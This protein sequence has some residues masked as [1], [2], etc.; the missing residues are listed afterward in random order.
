MP[1][2]SRHQ[3]TTL[4]DGDFHRNPKGY[5]INSAK[6]QWKP[7]FKFINDYLDLRPNKKMIV[8]PMVVAAMKTMDGEKINWA[9]YL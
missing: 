6:S 1:D 2:L 9:Q 5:R 3:F 7:W 8:A 4:F